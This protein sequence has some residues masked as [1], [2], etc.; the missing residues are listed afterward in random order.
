M[1]YNDSNYLM[2]TSKRFKAYYANI[3]QKLED[4]FHHNLPDSV[5][6]EV[7]EPMTEYQQCY[8]TFYKLFERK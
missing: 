5:V 2:P 1:V 3:Q 8:N 7:V 6:E 4:Y